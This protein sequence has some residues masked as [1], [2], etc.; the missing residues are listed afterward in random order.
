MVLIHTE[1]PEELAGHGVGGRLVRASLDRAAREGLTIVPL[2]PF[3]RRWLGATTPTRSEASRW[4]GRL[5]AAT[6]CQQACG[7]SG[8]VR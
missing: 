6:A 5:L 7:S 3:A 2:C 8:G 1:V 4:T